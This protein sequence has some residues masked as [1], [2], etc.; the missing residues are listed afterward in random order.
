[1]ATHSSI[2]A[3]RIPGTGE[4][5]GL[6]SMGSHRVGHDWSDLAAAAAAAAGDVHL[7]AH[8]PFLSPICTP[9][10][11]T[12]EHCV[13]WR[14]TASI[15]PSFSMKEHTP[16]WR[17]KPLELGSASASLAFSTPA[18]WSLAQVR[19]QPTASSTSLFQLIAC[20]SGLT[21]L[22]FFTVRFSVW[23]NITV[24]VKVKLP[25]LCLT[26]WDPMDYRV[27]GILQV[28]IL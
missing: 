12:L 20:I 27:H 19:M 16:L 26:L 13:A 6:P 23:D 1:M 21:V 8:L 7:L 22:L 2:L 18:W 11:C 28:K 5:G 4:P 3:W 10:H 14:P 25:Q 15:A 9:L 24:K 17:D